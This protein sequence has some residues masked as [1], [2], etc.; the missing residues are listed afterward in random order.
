MQNQSGQIIKGYDLRERIGAGGFGAVYKAYQTTVS[1]EVAIK[2]ILP[3]FASQPDFIRRFEAEAQLIARL[4]HLHIVPLYDYWRDPEGAYLVMRWMRGGNLA[5]SLK[6]RPY[7]LESAA[8]LLGQVASAL[9]RAHKNGVV[10]RDIKPANIFLDEDGNSYLG[11]FGIAKEM[12]EQ[13]IT[14]PDQLVGSPDYLAPEQARNEPVTPQTDI[15]SLGVVLYEM[16]AGEHPFP[17]L[18]PVERM[19]KHLN[20]PLPLLNNLNSEVLSAINDVIQR[21]TAKN[22]LRRFADA[23]ELASAFREAISSSLTYIGENIVEQLTWREQEIL[24]LLSEGKSNSEIAQ[25]LVVTVA[26]VRWYLRLI[27]K[28]LRV[29]SRVQAI[30]RA[31]ELNLLVAASTERLQTDSTSGISILLPEPE[32]PYK[33]LRAFQTADVR[34]FF[35]R[36]ALTRKLIKRLSDTGSSGRFLAVVGPSGSGKSS[37]IKAGLVPALWRGEIKRSE[38]WFVVDMLPGARPLDELEIALTRVAA[39]QAT[40]LGE[41]LRRDKAGLSRAAGLILPNDDSELVVII[42]QFE[43]VFTLVDD[44]AQRKQFLDLIQSSVADPRGRVRVIVTLRADFYDRPL[45]YPGLAEL[46]QANTETV[47]PLTLDELEH[48]I[49]KPAEQVGVKF[50]EG[51]VAT[52]AGE[53]H[54][55]PGALPLLQ[56]A[57]TELFEGRQG[58]LMTHAAYQSIG[59]TVGS[60]AKRAEEIFNSLDETGRAAIRQMF[61]RLVTLGEGVEDTRRRVPRHE[62]LGINPDTDLIEEVLDTYANYRLLSLDH[63]PASRVPTIEV[64]HEAILREWKR[65]R[66]WLNESRADIR[67]QRQLA[68]VAN[69]W[70]AAGKD[71]SFLLRGARLEQFEAWS[72]ATDLALTQIEKEYLVASLVQR[73]EDE[74]AE[75][76]RH[77]RETGLERRARTGLRA[78]VGVFAL[79]AVISGALA[80]WA[81]QQRQEALRQASMGLAAQSRLE[82]IQGQPERAVLLALEALDHYPYTWQAETALFVAVQN[83]RL[84]R[85]MDGHEDLVTCAEWSPDGKR[86]LTAG[87]DTAR[88]WDAESGKMLFVLD[89]HKDDLWECAWSPN[90][91]QVVTTSADGTAIV[92]DAQTGKA[93]FTLNHDKFVNSAS[94]SPDGSRIAT[95]SDDSTAR[96][97]DARTGAL[98]FILT[99]HQDFV[100]RVSWSPDGTQL[101]TASGDK[102]A[103]IW[104]AATGKELHVLKGHTDFVFDVRWSP[105]GTRL[106]T[107]SWPQ[108]NTTRIWDARTGEQLLMLQGGGR[109]IVWHVAWSPDGRRLLTME[110]NRVKGDGFAAIWDATTGEQ[111]HVLQ[112]KSGGHRAVWSPDGTRVAANDGAD[113]TR[114]WDASTGDELF[115]LRSPGITL[116]VNWSPEGNRLVTS[117]GHRVEI[118]DMTSRE[119]LALPGQN[120]MGVIWSPD[121]KYFLRADLGG[122]LI[123]ADSQTF[124]TIM[125][126]PS[127]GV[128]WAWVDWSPDGSSIATSQVDGMARIW[129]ARTGK[130]RLAFQIEGAIPF[131]PVFWS[132]KGTQ[133]AYLD[134]RHTSPVIHIYDAATGNLGYSVGDPKAKDVCAAAWSPDG[135]RFATG[136]DFKVEVFDAA[137]G[138]LALTVPYDSFACGIDWSPD[139][140]RLLVPLS[141]GNSLV[142]DANTGKTL[143]TYGGHLGAVNGGV[144]SPDGARVATFSDSE[145]RIWDPTT[146]ATY[147]VLNA[148]TWNADWSPD[149]NRLITMFSDGTLRI[150]RV[151]PDTQSLIAYA[152]Q[153]CIL[154]ELTPKERE[155]FG[156]PAATASPTSNTVSLPSISLSFGLGAMG[157]LIVGR[158]RQHALREYRF[159][160]ESDETVH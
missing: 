113:L 14:Q 137:T 102:T 111:L 87:Y 108:D 27:Y 134:S 36:E 46:V 12:T 10:H 124:K 7:D 103:R 83:N 50:E 15:Y 41:H 65:L 99:G 45:A 142:L 31:R 17:A 81:N 13:G 57:L 37:L 82:S 62:I 84:L 49:V 104:D 48:V 138:K 119:I 98:M 133:V 80:I 116:A 26:T 90:G 33:G 109:G 97:W 85:I 89:G 94:W 128:N 43:E 39:D 147:G 135:T 64:A 55:Q 4:E 9:D 29:R 152:K 8:L 58:R 34:D 110:D 73:G 92:W 19:F 77:A 38:K 63:D 60:L 71:S 18:T 25:E 150:W 30:V 61:L 93:L 52:I 5:A 155:L 86:L 114:V 44:E 117:A 20:D 129:D 112:G 79:A 149:G 159:S 51:L 6:D 160:R 132:P 148:P 123:V 16:L 54:Y 141:S 140:T 100:Q 1:R 131:S 78:L 130:E 151:F 115:T 42:D 95:S 76:A 53:V 3:R 127:N 145:I 96:I 146:G 11:D 126:M 101:A 35:G 118:W 106:A 136:R 2:I 91:M 23:L 69:D 157:L 144:W 125:S 156:L 72:K 32:N 107:G 28:K 74:A 122:P 67:L 120:S 40:N 139:G 22:P 88:L 121:G 56:Y 68:G 21:A 24:Q 59:G 158:Q 75:S 153:C 70:D 47:L 105:D 66:E 143:L 154:R